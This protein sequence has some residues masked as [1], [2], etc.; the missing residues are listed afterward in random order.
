MGFFRN[1]LLCCVVLAPVLT[2]CKALDSIFSN[3][4]VVA[5]A[6]GRKLYRSEVLEYLPKGMS[7]E[8]SIR[9][10]MQYVNSWAA[11]E[12]FLAM[13]ESQLSKAEK[14]VSEELEDY[15]KSLLK[16]KYEQLYINERLDTAVT[17]EEIAAYYDAHPDENVLEFP[18]VKARFLR[19]SAD[20]P[21]LGILKKKMSSSDPADLMFADS[22]AYFSAEKYTAYSGGWIDAVALAR[23]FGTDYGTMLAS[24]KNSCI[25][26]PDGYG[27]LNI[28]YIADFIPAGKQ[29][30]VEYCTDRIR[31]V[32][33]SVR[34]HR[35]LLTLE[36][37]LLN[38]ARDKGKIVIY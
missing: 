25:E 10:A 6:G 37:D 3:D 23:D 11:D 32:I 21:S 29:A 8:D 4:E 12:I 36:Q 19:I 31:D 35:L 22:L 34:K 7:Q 5:R 30:P 9:L 16:Y 18:I 33:I 13:A 28:A 15:R 14:D 38:D 20:S 27:R 1:I 24:M 17:D 26:M 2:S